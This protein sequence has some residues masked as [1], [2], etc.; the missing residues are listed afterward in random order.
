MSANIFRFWLII[1]WYLISI[2]NIILNIHNNY[3]NHNYNVKI[4]LS[5]GSEI[6]PHWGALT[7][8]V[9]SE[10]LSNF[11]K[12]VAWS[13]RASLCFICVMLHYTF[14]SDFHLF[15]DPNFPFESTA[16]DK[17]NRIV[18]PWWSSH[19]PSSSNGCPKYTTFLRFKQKHDCL[20]SSCIST[21]THPFQDICHPPL[22]VYCPRSA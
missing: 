9:D 19:L 1:V 4:L 5:K 21:R 14:F 16:F 17:L 7:K 3:V 11:G 8:T 18:S 6:H 12:K 10:L 20:P 13:L 15:P 2:S 22:R